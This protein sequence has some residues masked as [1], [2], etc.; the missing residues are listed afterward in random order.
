MNIFGVGP[1]EILVVL[2]IALLVFKPENMVTFARRMGAWLHK[3]RHNP[4][5][6]AV[7][8]T[9]YEI[10]HWQQR[11]W[12]ETGLTAIYHDDGTSSTRWHPSVPYRSEY[13]PPAP[14][15]LPPEPAEPR[16]ASNDAS[17][18]A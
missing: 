15:H 2:T 16:P 5:W 12:Q 3:I 18:R 11:L 17:P 4:T 9:S 6:Q 1:L 13:A 7:R 14:E 8:R 10:D